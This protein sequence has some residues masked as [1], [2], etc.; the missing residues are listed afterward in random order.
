VNVASAIIPR[1]GHKLF[2]QGKKIDDKT[3]EQAKRLL[4]KGDIPMATICSRCGVS[5]SFLKGLK[6]QIKES[7]A[8]P[9][10]KDA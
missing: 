6:K 7:T 4:T 10:K 3:R 8:T 1:G 9:P 2:K 5:M